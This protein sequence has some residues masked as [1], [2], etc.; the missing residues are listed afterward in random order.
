MKK[1]KVI[2]YLNATH[3]ELNRLGMETILFN[4]SPEIASILKGHLLI[5]RILETLIRKNIEHAERFLD[6]NR[7]TFEMK[8][9]L[10]NALGLLPNAHLGAAKALNKIRNSYAHDENYELSFGE[11]NSLKVYWEDIQDQAYEAACAKGIEEAATM[12]VIFLHWTFLRL[13]HP[14]PE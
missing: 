2:D 7:I 6:K 3:L 5:E 12:A 11:L 13:I 1:K 10:V 14:N 9:D 8:I 4:Y